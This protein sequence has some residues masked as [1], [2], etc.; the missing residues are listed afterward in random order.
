MRYPKTKYTK[1]NLRDTSSIPASF[2]SHG[3]NRPQNFQPEGFPANKHHL[4]SLATHLTRLSKSPPRPSTAAVIRPLSKATASSPRKHSCVIRILTATPVAS[5]SWPLS[6]PPAL[7]S[8]TYQVSASHDGGDVASL[9]GARR[10]RQDRTETWRNSST[11]TSRDL[12]PGA[13][14]YHFHCPI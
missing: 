5:P 6:P 3:S 4:P 2:P 11:T 14:G 12:V 13:T 9:R 10:R 7:G 1:Q 8:L